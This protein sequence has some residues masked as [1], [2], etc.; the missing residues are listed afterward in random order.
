MQLDTEKQ[1]SSAQIAKDLSNI[2]GHHM[3]VNVYLFDYRTT[4]TDKLANAV[5]IDLS[6]KILKRGEI[7]DIMAKVRK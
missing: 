3:D 4:I 6:K 5:Q 1:Y 2:V 7:R